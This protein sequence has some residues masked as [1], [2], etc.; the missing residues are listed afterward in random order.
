MNTYILLSFVGLMLLFIALSSG[1]LIP[2]LKN[3]RSWTKLRSFYSSW[4]KQEQARLERRSI[5]QWDW[6]L[7]K[8]KLNG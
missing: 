1:G 6:L 7:G 3:L 4:G 8:L 2:P 5:E